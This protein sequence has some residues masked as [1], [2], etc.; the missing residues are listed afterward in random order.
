MALIA[1]GRLGGI[2]RD[3]LEVMTGAEGQQLVARSGSRMD[4]AHRGANAQTLFDPLD[5]AVKI[6]D[7]EQ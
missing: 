6:G 3:D 5:A 1:R 4:P 7:S 2:G